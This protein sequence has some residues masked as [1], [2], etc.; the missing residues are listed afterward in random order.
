MTSSWI[1]TDEFEEFAAALFVNAGLSEAGRAVD[2][3]LSRR[4]A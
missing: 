2:L 4:L 3:L 1:A